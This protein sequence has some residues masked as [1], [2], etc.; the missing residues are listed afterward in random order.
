[1]ILSCALFLLVTLSLKPVLKDK[2]EAKKLNRNNKNQSKCELKIKVKNLSKE[3]CQM[4]NVKMSK[5]EKSEPT[6][7]KLFKL[8]RI[9]GK[10]VSLV[11]KSNSGQCVSGLLT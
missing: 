8:M 9:F 4:S 1:M 11:A 6:R 10:L 7:T 5:I 3:K 2:T